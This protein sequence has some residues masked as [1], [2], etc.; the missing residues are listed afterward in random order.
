M[1]RIDPHTIVALIKRNTI[2]LPAAVTLILQ[3]SMGSYSQGAVATQLAI[4]GAALHPVVVS[5]A[6]SPEVRASA[7]ELAEMLTRI[8]SAHACVL[9]MLP[10]CMR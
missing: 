4:D 6:A 10:V 7:K 8:T 1:F 2:A 5:T 9:P 3:I